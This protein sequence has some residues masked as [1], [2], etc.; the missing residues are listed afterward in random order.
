M[1][2]IIYNDKKL[3]LKELLEKDSFTSMRQRNMQ[4]LA[5]ELY[6]VSNNFSLPHMNKIFDIR[7]EHT[8]S[9]I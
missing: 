5:T 9:M 3:S 7:N 6:K 8:Y 2:R 4:M 1:L